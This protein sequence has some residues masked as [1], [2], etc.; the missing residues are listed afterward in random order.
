MEELVNSLGITESRVLNA[1]LI[2]AAFVVLAIVLDIVLGRLLKRLSRVTKSD[3]DDKAIN[4]MHKPL[5]YS[6]FLIGAVESLHYMK[7][8]LKALF[9]VDGVLYTLVVIVLGFATVRL[10][11]LLTESALLKIADV[12]GLGKDV[13]PF[14][15]NVWKTVIVA[16]CLIFV[17]SVWDISVTPVLASAGIMGVAVAL[18][19]KDTLANFFGGI[20]IFIDRPYKVGDYI[21]IESGER[22]EVV[23]IGIRSTRMKTRD[24]ILISIPNSVL[25]NTKIINES[26]PEPKFRIRIP[27]AVAYG[28]DIDLVQKTLTD[29]ALA[30]DNVYADPS[31]RVR[32]RTFGDSSI[33]FELLCWAREP[34]LRGRTIHAL[35]CSIYKAFAD[36][37]I[38]IPFP[39]RDVH[40]FGRA[41]D[42]NG[43]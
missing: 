34:M 19:A 28:S 31:P 4:I 12:T 32:F 21:V 1:L 37:G 42:I 18:A 40:V 20:S 3:T 13:I 43:P 23:E 7:L 22:G 17:L 35:N 41:P 24:D 15:E 10:S 27:V 9:Y 8:P 5:F 39:Q 11:N 33:N 36:K 38:N 30:N 25:A 6:I 2:F 16:A 26:A 29:I 14:V